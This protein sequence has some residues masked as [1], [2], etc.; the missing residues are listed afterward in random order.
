MLLGLPVYVV[1][2]ATGCIDIQVNTR[3]RWNA[4]L[5]ACGYVWCD[6][7]YGI[8]K[9]LIKLNHTIVT[10]SDLLA[11]DDYVCELVGTNKEVIMLAP[12]KHFRLSD[13]SNTSVS[14]SKRRMLQAKEKLIAAGVK[15][16]MFTD[17]N[18]MKRYLNRIKE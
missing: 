11:H 4:A 6:M 5:N 18:A 17:V 12:K 1:N 16:K 14:A 15:T 10:D 9:S 8:L 13:T 2:K 7:K 3:Q